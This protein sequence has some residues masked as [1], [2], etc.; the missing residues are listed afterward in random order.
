VG[1][2]GWEWPWVEAHELHPEGVLHGDVQ[3]SGFLLSACGLQQGHT[4]A[5]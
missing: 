3:A 5:V 1:N 2:Q 4:A